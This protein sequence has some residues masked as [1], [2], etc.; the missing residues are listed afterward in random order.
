MRSSSF[1]L[2]LALM[3]TSASAHVRMTAFNDDT[4]CVRLPPSNSPVTDVTS[5]DLIC[6]VNGSTASSGTCSISAGSKA[7]VTWDTGAHPG[8]E[9]VYMAKVD[10]LAT[11]DITG[12]SWFKIAEDGLESDGSWASAEVNS[13]GGV[14]NFTIP[15]DIEAGNYLVRGETIGLHVASSEGGAQFYIG[16][17]EVAV[18]GSGSAEPS[19]VSF[20]GAYKATDPGIE[21]NIYYPTPTTYVF[22]GPTVYSSSS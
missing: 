13:A 22:P 14:Y 18:T 10:N 19:G 11:T 20:P 7:S 21:I 6:N 12:L 2:S 15:S 5:D 4:T 16:C 1:F 17:A 3:A 9:M 8:P